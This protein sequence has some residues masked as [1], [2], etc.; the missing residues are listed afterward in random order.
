MESKPN[1]QLFSEDYK[2][3]FTCS[4]IWYL[5]IPIPGPCRSWLG[6]RWTLT[7]PGRAAIHLHCLGLAK[8][9]KPWPK[10]NDRILRAR[11]RPAESFWPTTGCGWAES[12]WSHPPSAFANRV[13]LDHPPGRERCLLRGFLPSTEAE[14]VGTGIRCRA[15][16]WVGFGEPRA[17]NRLLSAFLP[18]TAALQAQGASRPFPASIL[19]DLAGC[20]VN[21]AGKSA[22]H[23]LWGER[24]PV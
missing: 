1:K 11:E 14:D 18:G 20:L 24:T 15:G 10:A 7:A 13:W 8:G 21:T 16:F 6:F 17:A 3:K 22:S 4:T 12:C 9:F 19:G 5:F 2:V 23:L